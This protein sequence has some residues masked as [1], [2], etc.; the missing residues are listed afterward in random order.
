MSQSVPAGGPDTSPPPHRGPVPS[1]LGTHPRICPPPGNILLPG[2]RLGNFAV[3][4]H[5][6]QL[7]ER[8]RDRRPDGSVDLLP[9]DGVLPEHRPPPPSS[10][11]SEPVC[12]ITHGLVTNLSRGVENHRPDLRGGHVSSPRRFDPA[13][14]RMIERPREGAARPHEIPH[15]PGLDGVVGREAKRVLLQVGEG[16]GHGRGAVPVRTPHGGEGGNDI[17]LAERTDDGAAQDEV[18]RPPVRGRGGEVLL[19]QLDQPLLRKGV[20]AEAV[21]GPVL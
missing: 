2:V 20:P 17:R 9:H 13:H 6:G 10:V 4:K 3:R 5:H 1:F 7:L 11:A 14:D 15:A 19:R 8:H 21:G 12:H 18:V 16:V